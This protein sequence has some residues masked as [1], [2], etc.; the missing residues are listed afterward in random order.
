MKF[1]EAQLESAIIEL[2]GAEG[3][4]HVLG[5]TLGERSS[6]CV[7][8]S[9]EGAGAPSL[10]GVLIKADL[11]A[12][13]SKQYAKDNITPQEI[14]AVI[15]QLEAYSAADLYESNK[16]IMKLVADGFLLK[17]EDHTQKDLYIQ[18]IDYSCLAAFR[19]PKEGEVPTIAAEDPG[20]YNAAGATFSQNIFKIV[21]QLTIVGSEKRI[22]DGILYING[23]PLVVFEFK[24][25]I[26]EDATIHDAYKQIT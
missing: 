20:E 25:A 15:K 19:E 7:T 2:L 3:Y 14:E 1:T 8:S 18:L 23:L 4:P 17:R 13:L 9:K 21:T 26:R 6:S 5:E 16:A 11:R 10:P 22:P 24:S 12:F